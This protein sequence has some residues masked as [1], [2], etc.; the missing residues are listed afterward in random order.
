[1]NHHHHHRRIASRGTQDAR[2]CVEIWIESRRNRLRR[3]SRLLVGRRRVGSC[4]WFYAADG[5]VTWVE[6]RDTHGTEDGKLQPEWRNWKIS[7]SAASVSLSLSL[8]L[9][10]VFVY[11]YRF[12][13][14]N[15]LRNKSPA[16]EVDDLWYGWHGTAH[17]PV[18][19]LYKVAAGMI[20]IRLIKPIS[21][22]ITFW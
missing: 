17:P 1:M 11:M 13:Q 10:E 19:W 21:M 5:C 15:D 3:I 12:N 7:P 18:R 4:G 8:T 14:P 22:V 16:A 2:M 6:L 20:I 9:L